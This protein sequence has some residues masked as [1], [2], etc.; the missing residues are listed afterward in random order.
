M[1]NQEKSPWSP[2]KVETLRVK[3][4]AELRSRIPDMTLEKVM[5]L[6]LDVDTLFMIEVCREALGA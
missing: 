6:Q 4:E 3:I 1:F 2:H 5:T